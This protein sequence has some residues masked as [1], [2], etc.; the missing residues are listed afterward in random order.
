MR[1]LI[2][3]DHEVVRQGLKQTLS[4]E[5]P[6]AFFGEAST[7]AEAFDQALADD[8][9]LIILDVHMPGRAGIETLADLK[10]AKLRAP[11]LILSMY[12]EAEYAVRAL[13]AGAVGYI[14][15]ASVTSELI[16]AVKK[17]LGGGRYITP[18][19][20]ELLATDIGQNRNSL[21]H[22]NLSDREYEVMKLLATGHSVKAIAVLLSL[23]EKTVFTYRTRLLTKLGLEG[24]VEIARYALRHHL[25]E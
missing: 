1:F 25:V 15:K 11:V 9:D 17:A 20:A 16:E 24:D 3:D 2:A 6:D 13:K 10:K 14:N 8:W 7:A 23:S 4:D 19:L 5:F 21:P 22:H 12:S 18:A